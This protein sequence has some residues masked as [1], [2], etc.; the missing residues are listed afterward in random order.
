[1]GRILS[2]PGLQI[3]V[4]L[5]FIQT[6]VPVVWADPVPTSYNS[7]GMVIPSQYNDIIFN[8]EI[9]NTTISHPV[10]QGI[11]SIALV[12]C[13][14]I[15]INPENQGRNISLAFPSQKDG[16]PDIYIDGFEIPV[17]SQTLVLKPVD[18]TLE[19]IG[20][21]NQYGIKTLNLNE[22]NIN[23]SIDGW[24]YLTLFNMSMGPYEGKNVIIQYNDVLGIG[25]G[26]FEF[27]YLM[28]TG[29]YWNQT[30]DIEVNVIIDPE[31]RDEDIESGIEMSGGKI[32]TILP[33]PDKIEVEDNILNIHW[34]YTA[35]PDEDI[36]VQYS[37]KEQRGWDIPY[38]I[39][40]EYEKNEF[41]KINKYAIYLIGALLVFGISFTYLKKR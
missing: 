3:V 40:D 31:V 39:S 27:K 21:F 6:L 33:T 10:T 25:D 7:C 30:I 24:D 38:D 37:L 9:V 8:K 16:R 20:F 36:V 41:K 34:N 5:M 12:D 4:I 29:S 22:T 28:T 14:F 32:H 19:N 26:P 18:Y 15:F 2:N 17:T 35:I 23:L 1:M 11:H 13:T